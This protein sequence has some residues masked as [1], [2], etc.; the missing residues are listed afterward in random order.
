MIDAGG[1]GGCHHGLGMIGNADTSFF[2]HGKIVRPVAHGQRFFRLEPQLGAEI[3]K[4]IELC[5]AAED[6]FLHLAGQLAVFHQ[7]H[8]GL[9][10]LEA[11]FFG[12]A[13]GK[14]RK[15]AGDKRAGRAMGAHRGAKGAA[16]R[17]FGDLCFQH[18]LK[19]ADTE[20]FEKADPF[21][22]RRLEFKLAAHGPLGDLGD[23]RLD[24]ERIRQLVDT[25]LLDDGGI[26]I[27]DEQLL[28]PVGEG[29]RD[30]VDGLSGERLPG[31]FLA[32]FRLPAFQH[33]VAGMSL[34][35]PGRFRT[36]VQ[37]SG[38]GFTMILRQGLPRRTD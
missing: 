12:D 36:Q 5:L 21:A 33:K 3:K 13:G 32:A 4:R 17:H 35:Q 27:R 18:T 6:R 19:L 8:I 16:A 1:R 15:A 29:L 2:D 26:H 34:F 25:L 28:A 20:A 37:R 14:E 38:N 22:Q 11:D 10:V 23:L 24:A 9:I 30:Y 31:F 7:K